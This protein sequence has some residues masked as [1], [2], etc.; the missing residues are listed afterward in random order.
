MEE[1]PDLERILE[2]LFDPAVAEIVSELEYEGKSISY[3]IGKLGLSESKILDT[4]SY[5]IKNELIQLKLEEGK[6]FLY[7]NSEKLSKIVE[8]N[9][10][11]S[12]AIEG[13]TKM[14]SFLN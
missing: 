8:L 7:A 4:L 9:A 1:K 2:N 12:A 10:N 5:L 3:L 6:T 11:S 13:L 14:D